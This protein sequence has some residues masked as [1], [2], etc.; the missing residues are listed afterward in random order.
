MH[1]SAYLAVTFSATAFKIHKKGYCRTEMSY[2][3]AVYIH[4]RLNFEC[5]DRRKK[6]IPN[7]VQAKYSA[8]LN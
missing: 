4:T 7:K 2:L 3:N 5:N 8:E 1:K 6:T